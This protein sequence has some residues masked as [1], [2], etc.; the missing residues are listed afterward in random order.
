MAHSLDHRLERPFV[1][2]KF[3][4]T[5]VASAERWD[6]I[7]R[8]TTQRLEKYRVILV[9]SA[10]SGVTNKLQEAI[11]DARG[12]GEPT[13]LRW[14]EQRH[15]ELAAA[16]GAGSEALESL[17]PLFDTAERRLQG[18]RLTGEASPRLSARILATG[19]L[20][21]TTLGRFILAR[22]GLEAKWV[23][24]RELIETTSRL[25]D[26]DER[27]YLEAQARPLSD[28]TRLET[29][30][31]GAP[32]VLTQGFI[33]RTPE[34]ETCLLGRGG[35]DTSGAVIAE[36]A[37][38][39][40]LEIWTDVPGLFTANPREVPAARLIRRI[41]YR[42]AR[43]L[44][45]LG[46]KVLHPPCL[47]PAERAGI[48]VHVRS[49]LHPEIA[50]TIIEPASDDHP[51]VTAATS[52]SGVTLLTLSTVAMWDVSG[53]LARVFAPFAETGISVDLVAT[54]QAA[55][56]ITIDRLP[57]GLTG[58]PFRRLLDRLRELG[59]VRVAH[60]CA[61]VSIVGRRIRSVLP[62]LGGALG[63]FQEK[64]V[65][66]VS[67]SSEDLNLSFVVD[68]E[69]GPILVQ[70]LH[71][72]LMLDRADDPRFGPTW[73]MLRAPLETPAAA[74]EE[75]WLARAADLL[76][77]VA[78]GAPRYVYHLPSVCARAEALKKGLQSV[79]RFFYS[80]KANPHPRILETAAGCGFGI[81]CVSAGELA[82]ARAVLPRE[83]PLLFTPNFCPLHEY[84]TALAAGAEVTLDNPQ[85]LEMAPGL[86]AGVEIALRIDPGFGL[87]HHEKV[88]TG[89]AQSKFGQPLD[90]LGELL[91]AA[92]ACGARISG[93]HAHAGSGVFDPSAWAAVGRSLA[94]AAEQVG[95]SLRWIDL[96][97][98][99][100]VP[101]RPGQAPLDLAALACSL[102]PLKAALARLELRLE[103]GR[104]LVSEAGVLLA[105]VTQVRRKGDSNFVGVATGM[106]SLI[107]PAL[108][109]AWHPIVNLSRLG[110]R[111]DTRVHVVGPI[112]ETGDVIGRDRWLPRPRV[113]DV[114]LIGCAG[115]YG[116]AMASRYNLREPASEIV[117]ET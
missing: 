48:P 17:Q 38:A 28:P 57:G 64:P 63:A 67:D 20:A 117:L 54:S 2:M 14:V 10:L 45:T 100:G 53:F 99:L 6:T 31:A 41:G 115:A 46:A 59:E 5:S 70:R 72:K 35:S 88:R 34:G 76:R 36:L 86:F 81:E 60:P 61:V 47:V 105:P 9:C 16:T 113:G 109:G 1:V 68:E 82:R 80:M 90:Q 65:H 114:L 18:I 12:G 102:R 83:V 103:P 33:A 87:G 96:G 7:A 110:E 37:A 101:E 19:E 43:E 74:A 39:E 29:A 40:R 98:G 51:A 111:A 26:P 27:R 75:W 30:A 55:V 62:E 15:G 92:A 69:D 77:V 58:T 106:N 94:A 25:S 4:G 21:A 42:E 85:V 73:E 11:E 107:R 78:D 95:S 84:E 104:Y 3:G 8:E 97:G 112:C 79:D 116:A 52:R 91:E 56:S 49:T 71:Q 24:A 108:Y 23:D 66:L 13:S 89:G 93:L 32:L 22:R 44:A 50:G